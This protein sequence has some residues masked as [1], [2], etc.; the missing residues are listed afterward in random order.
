MD[1]W[2]NSDPVEWSPDFFPSDLQ[3]LNTSPLPVVLGMRCFISDARQAWNM[4][5]VSLDLA[6]FVVVVV[7]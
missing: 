7:V 3:L 5:A 1:W 4:S 6:S 2:N